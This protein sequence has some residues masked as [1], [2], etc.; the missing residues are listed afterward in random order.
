MRHWVGSV[1]GVVA[2]LL[3]FT[4]IVEKLAGPLKAEKMDPNEL[5]SGNGSGGVSNGHEIRSRKVRV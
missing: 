2:L 3:G 5:A 1:F 4:S